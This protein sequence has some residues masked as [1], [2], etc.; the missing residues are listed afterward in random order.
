MN[1]VDEA[2]IEAVNL[3]YVP[4][5]WGGDDPEK[6][7]GLDC[8][9]FIG[10]IFRKTGMLPPGYDRTA[11]GYFKRW[12]QNRLTEPA[13]G[14]VALYG[15]SEG[16]ITHIMLIVQPRACI[17]AVRGNKWVT[18]VG[19]AQQRGARIDVRPVNYRKDLVAVLNPFKE[20]DH[21]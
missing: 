17:G 15:K 10:Y 12:S 9:G 4:Y 13:R 14:G 18:T 6:D 3:L 1:K 19:R 8:S 11:Q 2:I 20:S 16:E 5:I 21:E 7:D